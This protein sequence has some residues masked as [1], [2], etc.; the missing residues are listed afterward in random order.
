MS[1]SHG[2]ERSGVAPWLVGLLA[3]G[4]YRRGRRRRQRSSARSGPVTTAPDGTTQVSARLFEPARTGDERWHRTGI[5]GYAA[6]QAAL[7][8]TVRTVGDR[9]HGAEDVPVV[10]LPLGTRRRVNAIDAYATGGR[11]GTLPHVAVVALGAS[12]R[13]T[14]R[15]NG[16]PCAVL[17]RI[18]REDGRWTAEV[19]L[20]E[21]FRPDV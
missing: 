18:A 13:A 11:I 5:D 8:L 19:L 3:L 15:A 4:A 2:T 6:T 1:T 21:V 20:P 10:L 7:D 16:Q 17:G 14:Q 12:L 9:T